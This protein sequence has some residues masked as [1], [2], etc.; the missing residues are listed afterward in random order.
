MCPLRIDLIRWDAC[1]EP[2]YCDGVSQDPGAAGAAKLC[3][4]LADEWAGL[5]DEDKPRRDW[6]HQQKLSH[7]IKTL[8]LSRF[9]EWQTSNPLLPAKF[10]SVHGI[11]PWDRHQHESSG[12]PHFC[13]PSW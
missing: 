12:H 8:R 4:A 7:V 13:V 2:R 10:W 9:L 1:V 6:T 3:A 11:Q 5:S